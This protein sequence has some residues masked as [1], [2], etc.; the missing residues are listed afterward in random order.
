MLHFKQHKSNENHEWLVLLHGLGG[1]STLFYKQTDFLSQHYNLLLIDLPGHGESDGIDIP[2]YCPEIVADKVID[3]LNKLSIQKP[4]FLTFSLGTIIANALMHR[5][6]DRIETMTLAGP[7]LRL[8]RWSEALVNTAW[9]L[10]HFASYMTFYKIFAH[11]MMPFKSHAISRHFFI[12]EATKLGRKEFVKWVHLLIRAKIPYEKLHNS[13]N[14][15][16]KF[17]LIGEDD[18]MFLDE[19]KYAASKDQF[20]RIEVLPNCGHVCI[21][22]SSEAS[23]NAIHSFIQTYNN[24]K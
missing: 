20:A 11:I 15:V 12:S 18:H 24:G 6:P 13:N 17:Y 14:T 4:H 16:P 10:R 8:N 5:V 7:V 19:A 22:E 3:L 2:V 1:N 9:K 21:I 23:N